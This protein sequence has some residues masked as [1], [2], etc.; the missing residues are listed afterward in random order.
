M[1]RLEALE[2]RTVLSTLTVLNNLDSGPGS[3]RGTIANAGAGD[4]I[5]FAKSV[6]QITLTSDELAIGKNLDIEGPGA[7]RLTISGDDANRVFDI[8][9]GSTV[10]I[11]GLTVADGLADFGG[12]ILNGPGASLTLTHCTLIDNQAV[13]VGAKGGGLL[14]QGTATVT[15]STFIGNQASSDAFGEEVFGGAI[16]NSLGT[17][18]VTDSSFTGN[19]AVSGY[20]AL[21]GAIDSSGPAT[22]TN[23][24]FTANRAVGDTPGRSSSG[25]AIFLDGVLR[26]R[27]RWRCRT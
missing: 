13:G 2:D 20:F 4:T 23:S 12:G 17:L 1:P 22:I 24:A 5:V 15:G 7:K 8:T 16:S 14:N 9:G 25:G 11:A 6:H 27:P 19:Q 26:S 18:T 3:L 21:G 10:T